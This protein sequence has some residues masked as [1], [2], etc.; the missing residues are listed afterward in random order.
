MAHTAII[1]ALSSIII[2]VLK[3][4]DVAFIYDIHLKNINIP[5]ST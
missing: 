2:V 3:N 4:L 1:K 5:M